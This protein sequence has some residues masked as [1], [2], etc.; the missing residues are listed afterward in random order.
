MRELTQY[1]DDHAALQHLHRPV[2]EVEDVV[3]HVPLVDQELVRGAEGGLDLEGEGLEA[4]LR[5]GL[6]QGKAQ[7]LGGRQ[8]QVTMEMI[9]RVR[10]QVLN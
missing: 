8:I 9:I 3:Q 5:G 4:A 10:F 2:G 6:E 1:G 7:H